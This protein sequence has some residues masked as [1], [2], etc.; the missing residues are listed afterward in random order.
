ML[1]AAMVITA[2]D[3]GDN[4]I[5]GTIGPRV[6][7]AFGRKWA[8]QRQVLTSCVDHWSARLSQGTDAADLVADAVV[9]A[10]DEAIDVD[11][12][13]WNKEVPTSPRTVAETAAFQR[14]QALFRVIQWRAGKCPV[15][16]VAG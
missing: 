16:E 1:A 5:C 15:P 6:Q 12:E 3:R 9:A 4:R 11:L 10:C 13:L 8:H 14:R 2:C 7:P